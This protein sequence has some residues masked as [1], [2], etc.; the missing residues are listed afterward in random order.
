MSGKIK[1]WSDL[2]KITVVIR[3]YDSGDEVET[4]RPGEQF[5]CLRVVV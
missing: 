4:L 1:K 2:K 5:D 3:E